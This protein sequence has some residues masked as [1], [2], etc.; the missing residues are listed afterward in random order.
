MIMRRQIVILFS[1]CA[2][3]TVDAGSK[4]MFADTLPASQPRKRQ[5]QETDYWKY[6]H[7]LLPAA[8]AGDVNA[9]YSL[10][11]I[12][13]YC[14]GDMELYFQNHGRLLT[15]D[16]GL[17]KAAAHNQSNTAREVFDHCHAFQGT[18]PGNDL[19][20]AEEWLAKASLGGQPIAQAVT[21][22]RQLNLAS[23]NASKE[24]APGIKLTQPATAQDMA[25]PR[26]LFLS[27]V[28]SLDPNVME[29]IGL[30]Q[31]ALNP[32]SPENWVNQFAWVYVACQRGL[33]CSPSSHWA[34]DCPEGCNVSTP[35]SII[36][37]WSR[38]SW[39][40]VQQRAV[41]LNA[42]LDAHAWDQLGLGP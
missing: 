11:W 18:G 13:L 16:E 42:K 5:R 24:I 17:V 3:L 31:Y 40:A 33:D 26:Q 12:Q 30:S 2:L 22:N 19:G 14:Y 27:A 28:Q 4:P 20:D 34:Q 7:E 8:R 1:V 15:L 21:A 9:Q 10:Y 29:L 39:P 6:A 38:D 23:D 36:M 32:P 25:T 35:G 37:A 41:E